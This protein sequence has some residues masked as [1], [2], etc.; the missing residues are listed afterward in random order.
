M[1]ALAFALGLLLALT[2]P[3]LAEERIENFVSDVTVNADASLNVKETIT[4]N[5]EGND[6]RHGILRDFP[7]TYTDKH[8][9]R[10]R[11]GFDVLDVKRDGR[12]EP[13]G[14]ESITN[15][16][17]IRI[18]DKDT[19]LDNGQHSYEITYT[20]TRQLGFFEKFDELYWNVTGNGWTFPIQHAAVIIRLPSGAIIQQ[21]DGYTGDQGETGKDFHVVSA[22]G[23]QYRAE[24]TQRLQSSQGFT[25]AVAWQ[26]GIVAPPSDSDKWSWW[27][28]DNAAVFG[29]LATLLG[30]AAY[31]LFA[32]NKVGRDPPKGTII[33]LFMPPAGLAPAGARFVWKMGFDDKAFAASLVGL[34]V[35]GRLK[36][37]DD[38]DQFAVTK[39]SPAAAAPALTT[40][41]QS[42]YAALPSSTLTLK[43]S[44][45]VAV[46]AVR[47]ALEKSLTSEYEGSA[48]ARNLGWFAGGAAISLIG[49]LISALLL[50]GDEAVVGLIAAGFFGVFWAVLLS[51]G[52][53]AFK[54][55]RGSR[56][57]LGKIGGLFRL[58]FIVPF[59]LA[60]FGIGA[61]ALFTS[62]MG[63]PRLYFLVGIAILLAIM[64][65]VFYFLLRAPTVPGRKLLDQIEGFRLYMTTAEEER[66]KVLHPPEKTPQLFERYLPYAL[67]LDCENEWNSKFAAVLAAAAAAGAAAP[68]WY[69][70]SHWDSG[71]TG[72][73][74]NSLG[75]SLSSSVASASTAPGSS[76]G[77]SGGGSS[78]G[79]GGGGG[80][81]GW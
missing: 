11:V 38:D 69:S 58:L 6:I 21:H 70:G 18:G 12:G 51:V 31:Y 2:L 49:L 62:G 23:D 61:P 78:G 48:F 13:Y 36:I 8:G 19:F 71:R 4:V 46:R 72:G 44:S 56:G 40:A 53:A 60:F 68:L 16:K 59:F 66:L 63:S 79:G 5:A 24:T 20:T 30:A 3:A 57:V 52:W 14:I 29:L 47:G 74:T 77:S 7:S 37:S 45:H 42:L 55:L 67:A 34:A 27:I 15:G 43:Q 75:S 81:S 80:G 33:P 41:E 10:V 39:L 17:R 50:P 25:V 64:N 54:G 32:W 73:F 28:Q 1:R 76:S 26:K 9:I 35:K 22:S 65:L